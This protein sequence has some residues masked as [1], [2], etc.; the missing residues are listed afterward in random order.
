MAQNATRDVSINIRAR[1]AQ[2]DLIDRAAEAIGK[3]R[4]D[5]MLE[6]ACSP[7][8]RRGRADGAV[9]AGALGAAPHR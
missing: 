9:R 2:R 6:A 7:V 3:N 5:F 1:N 8:R 4:S